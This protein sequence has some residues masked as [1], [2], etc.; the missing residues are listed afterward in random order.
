MAPAAP[1]GSSAGEHRSRM[2]TT[3]EQAAQVT[4]AELQDARGSLRE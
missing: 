4:M 1:R 2:I 3:D